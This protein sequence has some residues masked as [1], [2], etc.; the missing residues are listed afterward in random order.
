MDNFIEV[1]NTLH[2]IAVWIY[3]TIS[4]FGIEKIHRDGYKNKQL[5]SKVV[6]A[7]QYIMSILLLMQQELTNQNVSSFSRKMV[8]LLMFEW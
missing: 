3:R 8:K 6:E 1:L 5:I 2:V 4:F 7:A